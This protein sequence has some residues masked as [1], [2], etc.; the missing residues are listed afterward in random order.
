MLERCK[1]WNVTLRPH[2]KTHKTIEGALYQLFGSNYKS[3][4]QVK[5]VKRKIVV[6]TMGEAEVNTLELF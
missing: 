3:R 4:N 1:T 5:N 2:I 6:A